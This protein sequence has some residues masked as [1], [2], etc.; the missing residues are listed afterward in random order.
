MRNLPTGTVTLL[1]TDIEGSTLLLQQ[2]GERYAAVL[3]ECRQLLRDI[4]QRWH[5]HEVDT[6]GDAFFV[7]FAR[8]TDAVS[9]A[10]AAQHALAAHTWP[11]G[12]RVRVRMGLHTGEPS[13]S[14]EGYVGVDV[15]R[16]ARI[17]SAAHGGQ[18]LLSQTTKGLV[19]HALPDGVSLKDMG[20]HH[21]KGLPRA[22]HLFQL[23]VAG[24]PADFPPLR[25]G[26]AHP[27]SL[28]VPRSPFIGREKEV[29]AVRQLLRR[30]NVRLL[31]LTGAG[32]TGKTRL[33]L[34]VATDLG[35]LG[36]DGIYFVDLAPISDPA[37]VIATVAQTLGVRE[38][39]GLP[40]LERL[41]DELREKRVMLVL[42]NFEQVVD[43][44]VQVAD[45]L[46]A[47]PRLKALVTSRVSL[48]VQAEHEFFVPPLSLPDP[49]HLPNLK[50]LSQYEAV[51]L[52]IRR[53]RAVKPDFQV[54][55]ANAPAVAEICVRLDGLPLAIELAAA[56]M[57]LLSPEAL[58]ARL[59]QRLHVLTGG[60]RDVA[61][62]Q[63]T[64][65]NTIQ[66][67][68]QLLDSSEQRLFWRLA[69]FAGGCTL[70]AVEAIYAERGDEVEAVLD[71]LSSLV[72]KSLLQR[73]EQ[74]AELA[75]RFIMLETIREF[76]LERQAASGETEAVRGSHAACYLRFV[77]E[78]ERELWGPQQVM[79]LKRLE[80]EHDNLRAAMYWSLEQTGSAREIALRLGIALRSF[81]NT[82]GYYSEGRDF[83]ERVLV[84]SESVRDAVR[85]NGLYAAARLNEVLGNYV[86]AEALCEQSLA[87]YRE[88]E[89]T[90]GIALALHLRADL[91]WG[92]GDLA[93]AHSEAEESL[94][95]WR[96]LGNRG[97]MACLLLHLGGVASDRGEYDLARKLVEE[98]LAI[99]R[100]LQDVNSV[101]EALYNLARIYYLSADDHATIQALLDEAFALYRALDDKESFAYY[102]NLS[103]LLA[104]AR[105]DLPSARSQI[106][107]A[108]ALFKEMR[109]PHGTVIS[110][111]SL[112]KVSAAQRDQARA[113]ALCEEGIALARQA[114]KVNMAPGLEGLAAA[115]AALGKSVWAARLWGAAHT[116][117]EAIGTP[118]P[119]IE[120]PAYDSAVAAAR[121][122]LGE[123]AFTAAWNQ[124]REMTPEQALAQAD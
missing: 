11:E 45:L 43:A 48:H 72:D 101:G 31:T 84:G 59:S 13:L 14:G 30:E 97:E 61:A 46:S 111:Y 99:Q 104:L 73:A 100:E 93:L 120:R 32:G 44:A 40:L 95:L 29:T 1:F 21:F 115:V 110:L 17:M 57:K 8:A 7:A 20:E 5:G 54:T 51:A 66:W 109:Q 102:I 9:A 12:A 83:M 116:L 119:P 69:V 35:N 94:A 60:A 52:F 88:L 33:A 42:D 2:L 103:G 24:L 86:R 77:E 50:A 37:L 22:S 68:Y 58:L 121:N 105:G 53:A 114:G 112:A 34:Q 18:V 124:G 25:T 78:A 3:A 74:E 89:N 23:V 16:A 118:L 117:R 92:R 91:A 67:S 123:Q 79:W 113:Q 49:G 6:Q 108:V 106:E 65:R 107:Q 90:M 122:H 81:W 27:S 55:N 62:R 41:K 75:P 63:Q 56:R 10:V 39:S 71:T 98:C 47:C 36:A 87:L 96:T 28:P 4:F 64:L 85:A 70:E 80:Q 76:A 82:R 15:H 38:M 19:E 26:D